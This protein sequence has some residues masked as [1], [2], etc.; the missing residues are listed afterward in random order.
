M[1]ALVRY[2]QVVRRE[3]VIQNEGDVSESLNVIDFGS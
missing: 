3:V 2:K 1:S